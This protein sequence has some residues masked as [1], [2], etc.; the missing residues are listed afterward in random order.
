MLSGFV[1]AAYFIFVIGAGKLVLLLTGSNSQF[2]AIVATLVIAAF[3]N[4]VKNKIQS[5]VD[6]RFFPNRFIYQ[7]AIREM[8]H[9]LVNVVDLQKLQDF[10]Q[11]F[12][13]YTIKAETIFL[14]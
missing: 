7:D 4:P 3:F 13:I 10:L 11:A 8:N 14:I 9:K 12:F 6:R 2:V 5:F 1:V